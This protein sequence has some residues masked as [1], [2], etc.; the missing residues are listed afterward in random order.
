M[1]SAT[2]RQL[3]DRQP[4]ILDR[5]SGTDLLPN[6][7]E[8]WLRMLEPHSALTYSTHRNGVSHAGRF[9]GYGHSNLQSSAKY[10]TRS[11]IPD[12]LRSLFSVIG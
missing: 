11:G 9:L 7:V 12:S 5:P 10:F 2:M 6:D 3:H 4:V 1:S 8:R